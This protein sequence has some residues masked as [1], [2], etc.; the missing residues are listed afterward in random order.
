M[1]KG[2]GWIV[3]LAAAAISFGLVLLLRPLLQRHALVQPNARSSHKVPTPQGGGFAVIGAILVIVAGASVLSGAISNQ[4]LWLVLAATI[5]IAVVGAID[6][7]R[8]IAVLPRLFLQAAA[9]AIVIVALPGDLRLV[10]PLPYWLERTLLGFALLWFV[11]LVNFMDGI[12]WM[13]VAEVVPVTAG[14]VLFGLMDAL[15]HD[16]LVVALALGGAV[17]GF[18]PFNRPVARLFLGDVGSLPIGLLLGRLLIELAGDGHLAAALLMPLYYLT[19]ATVTLLRRLAKS[20]PIW[21][22]HRT[23]FYQRATDNGF[24]VTQIVGRVF[25]LNVALIALAATTLLTASMLLHAAALI[26]GCALVALL[27][28]RFAAAKA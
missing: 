8:T 11:N 10:P 17:I 23:H 27:L 1:S 20:E 6:D 22:A 28:Y 21:Q 25:G 3:F 14:L 5:V 4:S 12:D 13:T 7:V 19:D 16:A 24:T 9:V 18:A 15:P 26:A 2:E